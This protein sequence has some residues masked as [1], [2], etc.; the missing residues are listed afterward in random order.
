[1]LWGKCFKRCGDPQHV[2]RGAATTSQGSLI[3]I[4]PCIKIQTHHSQLL[5]MSL[6]LREGAVAALLT[7]AGAM[8][9]MAPPEELWVVQIQWVGSRQKVF[10]LGIENSQSVS[11]R[12]AWAAQVALGPGVWAAAAAAGG[13]GPGWAAWAA[14]VALGPGVWVAA[15]AAAGPGPGLVVAAVAAA[16]LHPWVVQGRPAAVLHPWEA[17]L[18]LWLLVVSCGQ[19]SNWVHSGAVPA[20]AAGPGLGLAAAAMALLLLLLLLLPAAEQGP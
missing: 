3:S 1:M 11:L 5:W 8:V 13:P 14:Q 4:A 19:A 10:S 2:H 17:A 6:L 20:A 7:W 9:M 15:A 12:A 16:A 18:L